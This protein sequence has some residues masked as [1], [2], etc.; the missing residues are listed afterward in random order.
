MVWPDAHPRISGGRSAV[1]TING[2]ADSRASM[3]AGR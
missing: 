1:M 2:T 3:I